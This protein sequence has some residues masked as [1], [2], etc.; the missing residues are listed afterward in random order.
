M[1]VGAEVSA[2]GTGQ[3]TEVIDW[4][5]GVHTAAGSAAA[6]AA[7]AA[8]PGDSVQPGLLAAFSF[9]LFGVDPQMT[10][11]QRG[12]WSASRAETAPPQDEAAPL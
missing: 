7:V 5:Y 12:R 3:I 2:G 1:W 8:D 10:T 11:G 9:D 6:V 4:D